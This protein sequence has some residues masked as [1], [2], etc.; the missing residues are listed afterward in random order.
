[1]N[2]MLQP[3]MIGGHGDEEHKEA[4]DGR[5]AEIVPSGLIEQDDAAEAGEKNDQT[6][7]G[8]TGTGFR[9]ATDEAVDPLDE[10]LQLRCA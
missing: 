5:I 2:P 1:M 10:A 7:G 8:E 6:Q 9:T 3:V 4:G